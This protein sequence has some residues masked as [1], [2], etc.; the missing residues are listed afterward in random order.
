MDRENT[1]SN[2]P[3]PPSSQIA[4]TATDFT[5]EYIAQCLNSDQQPGATFAYFVLSRMKLSEV[6]L[7]KNSEEPE[8]RE[9]RVVYAIKV[10]RGTFLE[11]YDK[12][13]EMN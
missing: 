4:G 5:K 11:K 6:S 8:R 3:V 7:L 1:I 12:R 9:M 2:K 13:N 10:E